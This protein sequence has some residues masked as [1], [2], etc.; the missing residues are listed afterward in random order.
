MNQQYISP[1]VKN[2][3]I[4]NILAFFIVEILGENIKYQ[5]AVYYPTSDFFKP[6]QLVTYM[7][8]HGGITH[9]AFNMLS[10]YM[11]GSWIEE[12]LGAQRFLLYYL[13]CGFGA[14]ILHFLVTWYSLQQGADTSP[15]IPMLGAS[16]AIFGILTAFG[17]LYPDA[18]IQPLIPPIPMKAKY[19]VLTYAGI[20]LLLGVSGYQSGVAH[21]AHLGGALFGFLLLK[22]WKW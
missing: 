5:L 6:F 22:F 8:M 15:D 17:M 21:F 16:G 13:L 10:L 19:A 1:V 20:E 4:I 11:F 18:I 7:F 2:L 9:L 12:R 3:L 14:L